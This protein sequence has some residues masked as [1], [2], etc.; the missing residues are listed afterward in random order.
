MTCHTLWSILQVCRWIILLTNTWLIY[1]AL[2]IYQFPFMIF[3]C[4]DKYATV[5]QTG[6]FHVVGDKKTWKA[7]RTHP[8][9][10]P[11]Q[12]YMDLTSI[13]LIFKVLEMS[14]SVHASITRPNATKIRKIKCFMPV[15]IRFFVLV[16]RYHTH[17]FFLKKKIGN[18][19]NSI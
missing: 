18:S 10:L 16:T 14:C 13:L 5:D 17:A 6:A 3:C 19:K 4:R 1:H 15:K 9:C 2:K 12:F 7:I 11:S 8:R